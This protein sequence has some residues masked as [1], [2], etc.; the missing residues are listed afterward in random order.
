M[1]DGRTLWLPT[2]MIKI[3]P[4]LALLHELICHITVMVIPSDCTILGNIE[5]GKVDLS[6]G[7][8]ED[9]VATYYCDK[10]YALVGTATRTCEGDSGWSGTEPECIYGEY[11]FIILSAVKTLLNIHINNNN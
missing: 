6:D 1:D 10:D 11:H 5:N 9:S 4:F 3:T 7:H 2:T 8:W